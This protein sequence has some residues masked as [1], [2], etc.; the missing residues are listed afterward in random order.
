MAQPFERELG[1]I[2]GIVEMTSFSANGGAQVTIQF[3]LEKDIDVAA[4]EVQSAINAAAPNLP[5]DMPTPP[6]YR[7]VIRPA[8]RRS[9]SR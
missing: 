6:W 8:R 5:K 7:K 4:G 1:V 9:R 3:A 2:A